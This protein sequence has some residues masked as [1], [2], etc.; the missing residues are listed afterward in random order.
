M[1]YIE[2]RWLSVFV[3]AG[4]I[5]HVVASY[6][7]YRM[8]LEVIEDYLSDIALIK[9]HREFYGETYLGR[10]MRE[11]LV[12]HIITMPGIFKKQ[13]IIARWKVK[14]VPPALRFGVKLNIYSAMVI[15]VTMTWMCYFRLR[16]GIP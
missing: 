7:F 5:I 15:A 9:K 4:S 6:I 8:Y 11:I 14:K 16:H 2:T 12:T 3:F 1:P 10:K 13:E